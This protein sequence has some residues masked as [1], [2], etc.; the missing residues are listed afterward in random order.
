MILYALK[1][2]QP[3]MRTGILVGK[4]FANAV[5]RNRVKR[6]IR[7]A[8]RLSSQEIQLKRSSG[9][10]I[11]VIPRKKLLKAKSGDLVPEMKSLLKKAVK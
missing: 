11:V 10:D 5:K 9:T 6:L 4:R 3:F 7:E 8:F 2:D 1:T